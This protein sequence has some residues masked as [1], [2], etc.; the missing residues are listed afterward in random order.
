MRLLLALAVL[1]LPAV[2]G[3]DPVREVTSQAT[4]F[5]RQPMPG[6]SQGYLYWVEEIARNH[7]RVYAPD[8][9]PLLDQ[10][11]QPDAAPFVQSVA[12]DS[13]GTV[14]VSY[15]DSTGEHTGIDL[16]DRAG[17]RL[18]SW[19]TGMYIPRQLAFAGDHSVWSFG[20][21]RDPSRPGY[22]ASEY[23]TVRHYSADG[24]RLGAYLPRSLFPKGLPPACLSW[25]EQALYVTGDR[26]GLLACSGE[27]SANPEWVELDPN[28]KLTGRW[29][30]GSGSHVHVALTGDGHVYAQERAYPNRL[31]VLTLDRASGAFEPVPWT[32]TWWM[33]GTDGSDLVF[34]DWGPGALHLRWYPQP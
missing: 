18:A 11:I 13:N 19:S 5:A 21:E 7:I 34:A 30:L 16:L 14:A 12:V 24:R 4:L 6:F 8:G 15:E 31:R 20:R 3:P 23:M 32:V 27:T 25:Q 28:G 26:V 33:C 2:A 10:S 17:K 1:T 22:S 9:Q 29:H